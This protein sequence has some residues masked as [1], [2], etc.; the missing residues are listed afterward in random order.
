MRV[1]CRMLALGIGIR[2]QGGSQ[3][4]DIDKVEVRI[5][6]GDRARAG[7]AEQVVLGLGGKEFMIDSRA[8]DFQR[9]SDRTYVL[10]DDA[11]ISD[12]RHNNP[13]SLSLGEVEANPV[14]I[15]LGTTPEAE[16]AEPT[17]GGK[18]TLGDI[19]NRAT[20]AAGNAGDTVREGLTG[21]AD[22]LRRFVASG[23]WNVEEVTVT[24]HAG[25]GSPVVYSALKGPDNAW[26]GGRGQPDQIV[27][28]RG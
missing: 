26:I 27:L 8:N 13:R 19:L 9:G 5:V 1:A 6:T 18:G 25:G 7:T 16:A 12:A 24:V 4:G 10:G 3:M 28:Q 2:L 11:T 21:V 22:S 20:D 15:R 23:D 14:Y 17:T